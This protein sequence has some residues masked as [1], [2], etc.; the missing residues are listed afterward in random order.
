LVLGELQIGLADAV[1]GGERIGTTVVPGARQRNLELLEA[2]PRDV[3]Q[4]LVAIAEMPVRR[5][6]AHA[7]PTRPLG[8][9]E[10]G[11]ALLR[12]QLERRA[13]Q[14]LLEVAVVIAA[15]TAVRFPAHVSDLYI[16]S[17]AAS[18]LACGPLTRGAGP[19]ITSTVASA[20]ASS[21]PRA[22]PAR[23]RMASVCSV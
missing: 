21:V 4:K 23:E 18:T 20:I 6:R 15:L 17:D 9:G 14:G 13:H 10:A 2:A 3:G 11:R 7:R 1:K 12:D 22:A 8:K 19:Q 5:G 16:D